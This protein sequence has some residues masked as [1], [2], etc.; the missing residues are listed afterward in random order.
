MHREG[1]PPLRGCNVQGAAGG[2]REGGN[3][4]GQQTPSAPSPLVSYLQLRT[5]TKHLARPLKLQGQDKQHSVEGLVRC[6]QGPERLS[7]CS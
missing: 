5:Q 3:R 4:S 2:S 1:L 7:L 6:R